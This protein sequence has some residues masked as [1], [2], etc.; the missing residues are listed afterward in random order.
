MVNVLHYV[1]APHITIAEDGRSATGS[2]YLH[3][4]SRVRRQQ[5]RALID[6]VIQMGVYTDTFVKMEAGWRFVSINVNVTHTN[7]LDTQPETTVT[8]ES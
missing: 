2:F 6:I 4:L 7:R 3:C 8:Q 1:T 5:D